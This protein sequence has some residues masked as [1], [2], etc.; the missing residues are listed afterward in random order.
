MPLASAATP[1]TGA[2]VSADDID[3]TV[4]QGRMFKLVLP[5]KENLNQFWI[6]TVDPNYFTVY[7]DESGK[8]VVEP[9]KTGKRT[10][11]M[12]L[13]EMNCSDFGC[14]KNTIQTIEYHTTITPKL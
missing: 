5:V 1:N 10:I 9:L 13:I 11:T 2:V 7:M 14:T 4:E 3:I 6:P 8:F 12:Q